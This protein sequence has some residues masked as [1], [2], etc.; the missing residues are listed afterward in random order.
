VGLIDDR[1]LSLHCGEGPRGALG[2]GPVELQGGGV[3]CSDGGQVPLLVLVALLDG[4]SRL[5]VT[6]IGFDPFQLGRS[7]TAGAPPLGLHA[8]APGSEIAFEIRDQVARRE[9]EGPVRE[10]DHRCVVVP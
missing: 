1:H 3:A 9:P 10:G 5:G 4:E 2:V 6:L 7:G 8:V